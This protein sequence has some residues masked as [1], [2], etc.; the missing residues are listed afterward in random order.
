MDW[1]KEAVDKLRRYSAMRQA[2]ESIPAEIKLLQ[3]DCTALRSPSFAAR[4][5]GSGSG[6]ED[7]LLNNMVKRQ[8]LAWNLKQV[9]QWLALTDR[10]LLALT[11][12]ER[13][14]LQRMYLLPDKGAVETLCEEL[15]VE[16]STVYRRR[17][18]AIRH[19]TLALYGIPDVQ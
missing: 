13:L 14:V 7:A 1:K 9:R 17:D 5:K 4:V 12:E 6:R 19:F 10:G 2:A 3:A 11:P 18:Q 15:G 8:E 16:Q